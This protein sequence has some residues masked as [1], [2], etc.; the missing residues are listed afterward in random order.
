MVIQRQWHLLL[1]TIFLFFSLSAHSDDSMMFSELE[2]PDMTG[3]TVHMQDFRG[4]VV[5]LNFWATWCPP[6]IKEMPSMQR[7]K[8]T[9]SDQPF[10]IV[11]INTGDT[12]KAI[13]TFLD[14]SETKL[15]FPILL[16]QRSV[17]FAVLGIQG[18]P[19]SFLLDKTG[20]SVMTFMGG[21]EWDEEA[22]MKE[23]LNALKKAE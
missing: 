7:L 19:M 17:S 5:L 10:E 2:F 11:A 3:K 16:D 15:T 4:K 23:I 22:Q 20:K 6:C 1:P 13:Q 21:R 8:D 9:L 14:N 18:L 12:P